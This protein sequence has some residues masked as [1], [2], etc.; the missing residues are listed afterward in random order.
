[1]DQKQK[2]SILPG[3]C[4]VMN[5]ENIITWLNQK[6]RAMKTRI[7]VPA[8][9]F[10]TQALFSQSGTTGVAMGQEFAELAAHGGLSGKGFAAFQSYSSSQVNGSQFFLPDWVNGEVVTRRNEV[11]NEGLQF[12][13]DKVRQELFVRQ[14]DSSLI[15]LTNKDEIQSFHLK[16]ANKNQFRFVNSSFYTTERPEVFYQVLIDDSVKLT[17]FKYIKTSFVKAD[18]TDMMKQREGDVY[19]AFVDKYFYF[20]SWHDGLLYPVQLKTKSVRKAFTDM[21]LDPDAYLKEHYQPVDEDFLI[22][23]VKHFNQK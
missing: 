9:L 23:M 10:S 15:L 2:E 18:L 11:Y 19:D 21:H 7:L 12:L 4:H 13:Y 8:L 14:K 20:L 16:D 5:I 17:L 3:A 1:M 6:N 22:E